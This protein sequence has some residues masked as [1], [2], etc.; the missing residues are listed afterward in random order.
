M[1][2]TPMWVCVLCPV[3]HAW[4][5]M[6]LLAGLV[7][8]LPVQVIVFVILQVISTEI[9]LTN[10]APQLMCSVYFNKAMTTRLQTWTQVS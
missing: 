10:H 8:Y 1:V 3:G 5:V 9:A 7:R 6:D 2:P 4:R